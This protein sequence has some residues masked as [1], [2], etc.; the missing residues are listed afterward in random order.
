[1]EVRGQFARVS[2][3]SRRLSFSWK[4]DLVYKR[5]EEGIGSTRAGVTDSCEL[6]C[7]LGTE[8]RSAPREPSIL[9]TPIFEFLML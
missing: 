3:L 2:P 7:V 4:A 6:L 8:P 1:M 9:L 5:P